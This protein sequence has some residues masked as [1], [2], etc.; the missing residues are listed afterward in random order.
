MTKR[1]EIRTLFVSKE[2]LVELLHGYMQKYKDMYTLNM[3]KDNGHLI[4]FEAGVRPNKQSAL[5]HAYYKSGGGFSLSHRFGNNQNL[6]REIVEGVYELYGIRYNEHSQ[7]KAITIRPDQAESIFYDISNGTWESIETVEDTTSSKKVR[8]TNSQNERVVVSYWPKSQRFLMQTSSSQINVFVNNII[9]KI[10]DFSSE[11]DID[12]KLT[13]IDANTQALYTRLNVM[14]SYLSHDILL[15]LNEKNLK[16]L[17]T[18]QDV[19]QAFIDARTYPTEDY[20]SI[21]Q[22]MGR[23][24]EGLM[25]TLF[26]EARMP[27]QKEL[28][29]YFGWNR[30]ARMHFLLYEI[31]PTKMSQNELYELGRLYKFFSS[32]RNP[33]SH[34]DDGNHHTNIRIYIEAQK[35]FEALAQYGKRTYSL[36]RQYIQ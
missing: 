13:A 14:E 16:L 26:S 31:A 20:S 34:G 2:S 9:A 27:Y 36:M 19:F 8:F 12:E 17:Y 30:E 32:T 21:V 23:C 18:F 28:K 4:Q 7:A 24:F 29:D 1:S 6:G 33:P 15:F 25:K 35:Q 22:R 10:L 11:R 3:L 5:I